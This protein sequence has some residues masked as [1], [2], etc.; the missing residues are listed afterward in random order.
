VTV[1]V[2]DAVQVSRA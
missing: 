2:D 1:A